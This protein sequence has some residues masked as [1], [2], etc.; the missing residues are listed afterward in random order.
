[1]DD[2]EKGAFLLNV[3][4]LRAHLTSFTIATLAGYSSTRK[5]LAVNRNSNGKTNSPRIGDIGTV[6]LPKPDT[7]VNQGDLQRRSLD[8][9]RA[10]NVPDAAVAFYSAA[11]GMGEPG[12]SRHAE[13]GQ[14]DRDVWQETDTMYD[15]LPFD[16]AYRTFRAHLSA[17]CIAN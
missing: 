7:A 17:V 15:N 3:Y 6:S 4:Y 13:D 11:D 14:F 10:E 9:G 5:P 1:M 12:A 2:S 8:N 16:P